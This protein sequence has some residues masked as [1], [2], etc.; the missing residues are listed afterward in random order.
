MTQQIRISQTGG[1]QVME[2]VTLDPG[3]PGPGEVRLRQHAIGL[4][5]IDVYFRTGL[6]PQ[7]LPGGLGL[8]GA[9]IVESVGAGVDI[10]QPGDR[11]AYAG[12]PTGAYAQVRVMPAANLVKLPDDISYE[13]AAAIM[14]KGLTVQ[15]LLRR[16]YQVQAGQTILFHAAAGGVGLLACQWAKALGVRMIGTVGDAQKAQLA[17]ANGCAEVI[18]YNQE[19]FVARVREL[20]HGEG[21][22]VVYDSVGKSTFQDSLDC[23]SPLGMMVSFGNAS[24]AVPEFALSELTRRGS[25]FITRPRLFDYVAKRQDLETMCQE[26]FT[27][28]QQNNLHPLI[29]QRYA[30]ADVAQAHKDLEARKLTGSAI[31][32]P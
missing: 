16:T 14:L 29:G 11:V 8:E 25:L 1:P 3:Q 9:G 19:S 15:Y 5:Y 20:T 17:K 4:N 30:L 10:V 21:V 13:T 23:L 6:Y 26:L 32:L 7:P 12:G 31:L 28:V 18:N 27:M 24:G 22:P 2:L